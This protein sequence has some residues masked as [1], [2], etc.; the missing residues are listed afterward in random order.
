MSQLREYAA[1]RDFSVTP[2]PR[3]ELVEAGGR[4][5]GFVVQKHDA[6]RL[7]FDFRLEWDGVLLSWA[8]TRGPSADPGQKRL[9]VRTEDHPVSYGSFEGTI[10]QKEYGGGTVMLWDTGWWEPMHPVAEGLKQGK[11]HFRLH[12]A[13]MKGGWALVRMRGKK[14]EKRENWLLIKE[15]DDFAGRS[16][17]AL[18]NRHRTSVTTGRAMRDIAADRSALRPADHAKPLPR[19]RKLQ[20][21]TLADAPPEGDGWQ[22][23]A[24]LDGYRCLIAVGKGGVRLYTRNGKD[25]SDRFGALRDPVDALPCEAALIDGEVVAGGAGDDF[26]ALQAAL[27]SGDPLIFYAFDCLALDGADL[28]GKPLTERRKALEGLFASLPPRGPLR[29]S[30]V[31]EG[32]GAAALATICE[33]GGEGIVSKRLDAPYRGGRGRAWIKSKCI[34]RAEFVIGG[35]SPSDRRGR[36]FASLLLGSREGGRFVYRGRVGSGFDADALDEIGAALQPLARKTP[37]FDGALPS[38]ADDARWVTP[39]LVAEVEYTEF[40]SEG[41]IRHGVFKGMREDKEASEVSAKQ[42]AETDGAEE[43]VGR[44]RIS[45][46]DRVVYPEAGLSKADVARHY[47]RVAERMLTH[48]ANRPLSLLRCPSGLKGDCFFQKHAG[49]GF[50]SAVRSMPIEEK[51]GATEDYMYVTTPEGL[52]GA[53]QMGTLEFHIW[54]SARDRIERPDRMVFD[55]DPDERLGFD[56]VKAAATEVREGLGAC[57]LQ[58]VPMITGGK[59]AHVIVPLRRVAGWDT[60]KFFARTFAQILA[61][62]HPDRYTATM[63]KAKRKGRTFIDWLRNERGSTAIAPYSLRARESAA[64]A[65]PVTWDE[66][67]RLTSA[68]AFHAADMEARLAAPCPLENAPLG[69]IGAA[70]VEALEAWA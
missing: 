22:H 3:A 7:H 20:L 63:S 23:E 25:W 9:A 56:A 29:L 17:D 61:E 68:D 49:K 64:V 18:V 31:L 45:S 33:A 65:V 27:K 10:P 59:G 69:S 36:S 50:P 5:P 58:S 30:P 51:D 34:R 70:A 66:L 62:R 8:V 16:A 1:K 19:F 54:G 15:R 39:N 14:R 47:A 35:W 21:A 24:K 60:V 13:R 12:G 57:G 38:E 37:P 4:Q 26:S 43:Q 67:N 28:T 48:A 53:A 55:L 42:E 40:T 2:E 11:L 52:I 32:N 41:R 46:A 6:S 44:V